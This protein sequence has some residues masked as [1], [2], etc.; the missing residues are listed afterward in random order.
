M[1]AM[2]CCC[3]NG[4]QSLPSSR[5][6][7]SASLPSVTH[8]CCVC[9]YDIKS[10]TDYK[11]RPYS[12]IVLTGSGF[13]DPPVFDWY[14]WDTCAAG[15]CEFCDAGVCWFKRGRTIITWSGL[16]GLNS[17]VTWSAEQ[18]TCDTLAGKIGA[19]VSVNYKKYCREGPGL[20]WRLLC[21][22]STPYQIQYLLWDQAESWPGNPT[23]AHDRH[24]SDLTRYRLR[25]DTYVDNICHIFANGTNDIEISLGRPNDFDYG[26]SIPR[27]CPFGGSI[28]D[29]CRQSA[30]VVCFLLYRGYFVDRPYFPDST[31]TWESRFDPNYRYDGPTTNAAS[32]YIP[33]LPVQ[34][35]LTMAIQDG[36]FLFQFI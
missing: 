8:P 21:D 34:H 19:S 16:A 11:T 31:C 2:P 6:T 23:F 5:S 36:S 12:N 22:V 10:F 29:D 32:P 14:Y 28:T 24:F 7:P 20:P 15:P 13:K 9:A 26:Y 18:G 3:T 4:Q 30:N 33:G 25:T 1:V 17:T 35:A 27:R